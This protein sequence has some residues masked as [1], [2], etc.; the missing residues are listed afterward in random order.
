MKN[1]LEWVRSN[2]ALNDFVKKN[3]DILIKVAAVTGVIVVA[4][5]VVTIKGSS[6][7]VV[8]IDDKQ[9]STETASQGIYVDI[10]GE[11]KEPKLAK[12]EEGS[13][14]ED[15]ITAAGGLTADADLTSINRAAFVEDGEKIYIPSLSSGGGGDGAECAD[16]TGKININT[17]DSAQLQELTGIGPV[18]AE[19]I[20]NYREENGRFKAVEDIKDVSGIGDKTYEKFKDDISV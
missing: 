10:G 8:K 6:Q 15:A 20:I 13:R 1:I 3:R 5:F 14:V 12:L 18:T 9:T 11:V 4:F 19:S 7:E 17:A 2:K 16:S